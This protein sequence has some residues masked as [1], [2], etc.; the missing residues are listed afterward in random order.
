MTLES[1]W[2]C[3]ADCLHC[4]GRRL[5]KI[6]GNEQKITDPDTVKEQLKSYISNKNPKS[7]KS[8]ALHLKKVLFLGRKADPYQPIE[9]VQRVTRGLVRVLFELNWPVVICSKYQTIAEEDTDLFLRRKELIHM[10]VEITP[11]AESDWELFEHART[12]AIEDRLRIAEDWKNEGIKV[13]VR[14]EPFIPGYHTV[15]Q[16][17][18]ILKRIKSHGLRSYNTYNLHMNEFT[19][20]RLFNAGLDIEKI[21]ILNQDKNWRITQRKLCQIAD[22]EG[23]ELGCP[24]FVNVPVNW[25]SGVNTCCGINVKNAFTF[26]THNW[27]KLLLQGKTSSE[28]LDES[29]E[30]VGTTKDQELAKIIVSG[31]HSKDFYTMKD[32]G[33]I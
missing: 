30:G 1:Y 33:I 25:T 22:E 24:D 19:M 8:Q 4:V 15:E 6:W 7:L 5:N 10:L 20:K 23:V 17:R 29:W 3:E 28:T 18:D 14:G 21:W 2:T 9:R 13:G 16:F 26:N 27:R 12:S 32:G 11:G 31:G